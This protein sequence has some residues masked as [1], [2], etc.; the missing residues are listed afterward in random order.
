MSQ[1]YTTTM[2]SIMLDSG[3]FSMITNL[4]RKSTSTA[5]VMMDSNT[6]VD[7]K[8]GPCG[9]RLQPPSSS[10]W[11]ATFAKHIFWTSVAAPPNGVEDKFGLLFR[12]LIH[13]ST[14]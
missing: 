13:Y 11:T 7:Y 4:K 14:R 10:A 3:L 1:H 9:N 2:W 12:A 8:V 5:G 6:L